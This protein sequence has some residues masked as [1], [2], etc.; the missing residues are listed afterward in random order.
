MIYDRIPLLHQRGMYILA[1]TYTSIRH[2]ILCTGRVSG[3]I[4]SDRG[5][6]LASGTSQRT[7]LRPNGPYAHI[8]RQPVNHSACTQSYQ[9]RENQTHRYT[10]SFHKGVRGKRNYTPRIPPYAA[11]DSR[12]AY[13]SAPKD[14]IRALHRRYGS[15]GRPYA[16][17]SICSELE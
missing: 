3:L 11:Y 7:T 17:M 4:S 1:T 2:D 8:S 5:G 15:C 16:G 10:A 13:E 6:H 9:P 12:C 14:Q